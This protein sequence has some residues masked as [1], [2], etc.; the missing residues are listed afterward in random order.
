MRG[1]PV[2]GSCS[3]STAVLS[4]APP[5]PTAAPGTATDYAPELHQ[6]VGKGSMMLG[7]GLLRPKPIRTA[8]SSK[9]PTGR[10]S[11]TEVGSGHQGR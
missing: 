4:G 6:Q 8:L 1:A 5:D 7:D 2:P 9:V 10:E 11:D 3:W